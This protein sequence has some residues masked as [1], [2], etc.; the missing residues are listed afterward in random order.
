MVEEAADRGR[1]VKA[2]EVWKLIYARHAKR[3]TR[4]RTQAREEEEGARARE[5][6]E[7]ARLR[8]RRGPRQC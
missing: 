5:E 1:N 3:T 6:E 7:G 4:T 2:K 8:L